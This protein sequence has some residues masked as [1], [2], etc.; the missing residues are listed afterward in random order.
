MSK[1]FEEEK[2]ADVPESVKGM[3]NLDQKLKNVNI[4]PTMPFQKTLDYKWCK[5]HKAVSTYMI[6][7][8]EGSFVLNVGEEIYIVQKNQM[9]LL[10]ANTPIS[11]WNVPN[12]NPDVLWF[13][14]HIECHDQ[15]YFSFMGMTDSN[16]VIDMDEATVMEIYREMISHPLNTLKATNYTFCSSLL[17]RLVS[18]YTYNR[19]LLENTEQEFADVFHYIH[20]HIH[21]DVSLNELAEEF[22]FNPT[23]F[24]KKFKK[25]SGITPMKYFAMQRTR[26]IAKMLQNTDAPVADIATAFGFTDIYY[27][28]EYFERYTGLRPE[29]YR[30][31]C[32]P[33]VDLHLHE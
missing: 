33:P 30:K 21:R 2:L 23:Y 31:L 27:F 25:V 18:M 8:L 12:Q 14:F 22:H 13:H 6:Y 5:D 3:K 19:I 32:K 29:Q 16:L 15:E 4:F 10:P 11:Y 24:V 9:A 26:H 28:R 17:L 20:T 7:V 1:Y